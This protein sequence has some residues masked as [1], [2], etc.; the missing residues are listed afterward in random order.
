MP[1]L[2]SECRDPIESKSMTTR[3]LETYIPEFNNFDHS[4][5]A[6]KVAEE[7]RGIRDISDSDFRIELMAAG[8]LLRT[9]LDLAQSRD[10]ADTIMQLVFNYAKVMPGYDV[11][12]QFLATAT[13]AELIQKVHLA[14]N[15]IAIINQAFQNLR[16]Q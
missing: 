1:T 11:V 9:R 8:Q 7:W 2:E 16:R 14:P 12:P 5:R 10:D 15:E 4:S 13:D 3:Y 6:K